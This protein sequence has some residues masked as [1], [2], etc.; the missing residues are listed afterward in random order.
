MKRFIRMVCLV[1]AVSLLVAIPA[2]AE[3]RESAFFS[4]YGTDLDKTAR[5]TFKIWFTV[6]ANAT[7]IDELGASAIRVYSSSDQETWTLTRTFYKED[8]PEMTCTNS[9]FHTAYITYNYATPGLYYRA[10]VTFYARNSTGTGVR[11]I[12]T[13]ILKM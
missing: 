9:N 6:T 2:Y 8:W 7:T 13:E 4:A 12:Y 1:L 5:E 3:S 10:C 11:Y